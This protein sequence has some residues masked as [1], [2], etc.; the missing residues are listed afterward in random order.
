MNTARWDTWIAMLKQS[1]ATLVQL[2]TMAAAAVLIWEMLRQVP[3]RWREPLRT[4][5]LAGLLILF[6]YL[7]GGQMDTLVIIKGVL[8]LAFV[9]MMVLWARHARQRAAQRRDV[10][11]RLE[12]LATTQPAHAHNQEAK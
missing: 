5:Y 11:M 9:V 4:A 8:S 12:A 7:I 2:A 1:D 6:V 10:Q 3:D